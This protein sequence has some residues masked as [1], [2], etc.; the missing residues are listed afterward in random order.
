MIHGLATL[1]F[2]IVAVLF[3]MPCAAMLIPVA[4]YFGREHAQA[5][6]RYIEAHGRKRANCPWWCGFMPEAWMLKGLLDWILPLGV[7]LGAV[8][9]SYLL[10]L[11]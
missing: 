9:L 3:R 4:F 1:I 5:E 10:G 7:S 8:V 11:N 2:C 6:Y